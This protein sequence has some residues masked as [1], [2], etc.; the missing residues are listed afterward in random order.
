MQKDGGAISAKKPPV[1]LSNALMVKIPPNS[2]RCEDYDNGKSVCVCAEGYEGSSCEIA[3][4]D[5]YKSCQN[6]GKFLLIQ[7][8]VK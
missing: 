3:N 4:C 6:G 5:L 7:Q 2:G 1:M 8:N